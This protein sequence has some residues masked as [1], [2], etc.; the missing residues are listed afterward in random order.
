[1]LK[2]CLYHTEI[3]AILNKRFWEI[4]V[5]SRDLDPALVVPSRGEGEAMHEEDSDNCLAE[6]FGTG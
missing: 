1:M 2:H 5:P 6:F 3:G 4:D